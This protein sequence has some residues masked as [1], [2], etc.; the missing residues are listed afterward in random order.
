MRAVAAMVP[1]GCVPADIG[2]DHGFVPIWLVQNGV[3]PH[4]Y[5]AD[6]RPGPLMRA[7][8]HIERYRLDAYITTVLSDGLKN[9]PVCRRPEGIQDEDGRSL[10]A[11]VMIAAGMGGK[12]T[13]RILEG[14]PDKTCHLSALILEPQS[15]AW[16]VR[17]FLEEHGFFITD[18]EMVSEDGKF[19]PVIKADNERTGEGQAIADEKRNRLRLRQAWLGTGNDAAEF[20]EACY[21]YGPCLMRKKTPEFLSWLAHIIRKDTALLDQMPAHG[22]CM[23]KERIS[24]RRLELENRLRMAESVRTLCE[25]L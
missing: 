21:R 23:Q 5:A 9:V 16:L 10:G 24:R 15:E 18:E 3:C 19:Y 2:C 25:N 20:D 17:R 8:E 14:E 7:K 13:I 6:V 22:L 4:V 1:D 12:L 11:S